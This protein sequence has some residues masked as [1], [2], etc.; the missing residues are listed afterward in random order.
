[1]IFIEGKLDFIPVKNYICPYKMTAPAGGKLEKTNKLYFWLWVVFEKIL[2]LTGIKQIP[3][4]KRKMSIHEYL[5]SDYPKL[6]FYHI[7][8][9]KWKT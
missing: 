7:Y 9:R 6:Y 4:E 8:G 1:M 3:F 5:R 2:K